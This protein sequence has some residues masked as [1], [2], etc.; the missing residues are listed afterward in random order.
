MEAHCN[1]YDLIILYVDIDFERN[2]ES[3]MCIKYSM[4]KDY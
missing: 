4:S 2:R 3:I 1:I